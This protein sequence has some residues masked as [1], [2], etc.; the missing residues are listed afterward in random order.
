MYR[1]DDVLEIQLMLESDKGP[2]EVHWKAAK[3]VLRY[4]KA[5]S[6]FGIRYEP[7]MGTG[8]LVIGYSDANYARDSID[9]KSKTGF[10]FIHNG[11]AI[12]W[13]SRKQRSTVSST[14]EAEYTACSNS[15]KDAVWLK[16]LFTE[17]GL[18]HDNGIKIHCD[19]SSTVRMANTR[20]VKKSSRHVETHLHWIKDQVIEGNVQL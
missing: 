16:R 20:E 15:A 17:L 10:A 9:F 12:T 4:L 11:A 2:T 18:P 6:D 13:S 7:N 14:G 8:P 3:R 5:T 1:A 19:N